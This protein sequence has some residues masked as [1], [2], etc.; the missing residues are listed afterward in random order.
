MI[1]LFAR[2]LGHG[3]WTGTVDRA[4]LWLFDI[5]R[6]VSTKNKQQKPGTNSSLR[7]PVET[8]P[9]LGR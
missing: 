4:R 7:N 1:F 2:L 3:P 6:I 9:G 8:L 5:G